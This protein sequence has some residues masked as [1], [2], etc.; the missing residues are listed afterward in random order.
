MKRQRL[1]AIA[2][3]AVAGAA[4]AQPG[5]GGPPSPELMAARQAMREACAA[6]MKKL[7]DGKEGREAMMCLMR[8]NAD[9][10][11]PTC[12]EAADKMRSLAP[13]PPAG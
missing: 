13:R 1:A 6:D 10:M 8:D 11:S 7:C 3:L 2:A 4:A 12:K 9:K 5:P